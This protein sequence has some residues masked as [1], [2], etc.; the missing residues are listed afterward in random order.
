MSPSLTNTLWGIC[1]PKNSES[2]LKYAYGSFFGCNHLRYLGKN[3]FKN[4][5]N[6]K[7]IYHLFDGASIE[8]FYEYTLEGA[9]GLIDLQYGFEACQMKGVSP[10]LFKW[11]PNVTSAS[12]TFHRCDKL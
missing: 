1:V 8:Y 4:L 6:C 2:P 11:C 7:T 3:V 9:S 5:S 10:N 12:H